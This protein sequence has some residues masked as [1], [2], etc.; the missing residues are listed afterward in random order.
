MF[1]GLDDSAFE[2]LDVGAFDGRGKNIDNE[3]LNP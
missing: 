1:A 2:A 3:C